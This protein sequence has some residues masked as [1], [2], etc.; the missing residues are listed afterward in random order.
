MRLRLVVVMRATAFT[1]SAT[2]ACG[3]P[4]RSS[5]SAWKRICLCG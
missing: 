5:A 1:S 4:A 3:L 2:P